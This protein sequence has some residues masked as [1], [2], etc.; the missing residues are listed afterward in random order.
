MPARLTLCPNL[1][2]LETSR[3]IYTYGIACS[4]S[5]RLSPPLPH[6]RPAQ[7]PRGALS[8]PCCESFAPLSSGSPTSSVFTSPG[9]ARVVACISVVGHAR[10]PDLPPPS[11]RLEA[12]LA[13]CG[14]VCAL[15]DTQRFDT[16]VY[17]IFIPSRLFPFQPSPAVAGCHPE[18]ATPVGACRALVDLARFCPGLVPSARASS[19]PEPR[20]ARP[21]ATIHRLV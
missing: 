6:A 21:T 10:R 19:P 17:F 9:I 7:L 8:P 5:P 20:N 1:S 14:C 2:I 11:V 16:D 13:A 15:D 4:S 12:E 3:S 18:I